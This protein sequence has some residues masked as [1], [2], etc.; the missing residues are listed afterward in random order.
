MPFFVNPSAS[1]KSGCDE[2]DIE[3]LKFIIPHAYAHTA[4]AIRPQV[5]IVHAFYAEHLNPLGSC[6]DPLLIAALTPKKAENP[7]KPSLSLADYDV[8]D[9]LPENLRSRLASFEDLCLKDW[10]QA[11]AA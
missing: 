9:R 6:P 4:S 11:L 2:R 1:A 3:L 7:D 10:P 8:P 5:E